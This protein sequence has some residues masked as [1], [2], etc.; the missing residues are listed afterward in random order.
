MQHIFYSDF[1]FWDKAPNHNELKT[2]LLPMIEERLTVTKEQ[3]NW[4]CDVNTEFFSKDNDIGKYIN[5]IV[6]SV[7]PVLDKLFAELNFLTV[8]KQSKVVK[9]WYN[10]YSSGHYQEVHTH[11]DGQVDIAGIYLLKLDEI[12]KTVFYS[13]P[14]TN[15]KFYCETKQLIEAEEGDIILF[16]SHLSHYVLPCEK[17][18]ISV[19]FNIRC[20]F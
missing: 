10:H 6:N 8:P 19:A 14:T 18:R 7:Y 11:S 17:D 15:T 5:L 12:N 3:N 20:E 9:I 16:P 4:I 2:I 13:Y 1:I